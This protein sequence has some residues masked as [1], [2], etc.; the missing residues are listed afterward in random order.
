MFGALLGLLSWA[1]VSFAGH[2]AMLVLAML[3]VAFGLRAIR[4]TE[5]GSNERLHWPQVALVATAVTWTE[6]RFLPGVWQWLPIAVTTGCWLHLLGDLLTPEGVPLL[7]P[8]RERLAI[9]VISHTDS[10]GETFVVVPGLG[11]AI[12]AL[13][14]LHLKSRAAA[15]D[16]SLR[17]TSRSSTRTSPATSASDCARSANATAAGVTP[18]RRSISSAAAA[19]SRACS[20]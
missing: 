15:G 5:L 7:W 20:S 18:R 19:A 10:W 8:W 12:L 16:A 2:S 4:L 3:C 6:A 13:A 11:V 1:L 14:W 17:W 9:P